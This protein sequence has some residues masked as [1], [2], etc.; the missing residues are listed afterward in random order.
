MNFCLLFLTLFY[1]SKTKVFLILTRVEIGP[2]LHGLPDQ[3]LFT[4]QT[5]IY[6][7]KTLMHTEASSADASRVLRIVFFTWLLMP[8]QQKE[9]DDFYLSQPITLIFE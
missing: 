3:K 7:V 2:T 1:F 4:S 5:E 8:S 6:Q 9:G